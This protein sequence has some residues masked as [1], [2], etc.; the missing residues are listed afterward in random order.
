MG[1]ETFYWDG[2]ILILPHFDITWYAE[3]CIFIRINRIRKPEITLYLLFHY[4]IVPKHHEYGK[5]LAIQV[6]DLGPTGFKA[7]ASCKSQMVSL[8][9][10]WVN[11]IK[12]WLIFLETLILASGFSFLGSDVSIFSL[13]GFQFLASELANGGSAGKCTCGTFSRHFLRSSR[14]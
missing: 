5:P 4:R 13:E 7:L 10:V 6:L 12:Q 2:L 1:N 11:L 14:Q 3:E 9:N 8:A